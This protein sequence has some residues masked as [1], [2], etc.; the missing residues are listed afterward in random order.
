[1]RVYIKVKGEKIEKVRIETLGCVAA[2]AS[3]E[4]LAEIAEGKK[5]KDALKI[6]KLDI[7][8]KLGGMT[9]GKVHC[10]VLAQQGLKKAIK[11]FKSG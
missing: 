2:I 3:S 4:A 6:S 7:V 9:P 1:M 11:D 10:S 8:K 5:L